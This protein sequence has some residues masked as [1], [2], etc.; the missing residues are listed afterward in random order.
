MAWGTRKLNDGRELPEIGFGTWTAGSGQTVVDQVEQAIETGFNHIDTAQ[1][2]NNEYETG[3]GIKESSEHPWITTK[4]SGKDNKGIRQSLQESLEYLGVKSVDLY[5]IHHP[6]LV[7]GDA[8]ASWAEFEEIKKEGLVKS[9][10][11]SNFQIEDLESIRLAGES[12]PAVN[13]ILLH[14]YVYSQTAPL[15]AY[16]ATHNIVTEAYSSLYPIT[17][18]K[19]GPLDKPLSKIAEKHSASEAGVLFAWARSKGAVIVTTSRQK[20]R[21]EDYLHSGDLELSDK[22]IKQLDEAGGKF[23]AW[24]TKQKALKAVAWGLFAVEGL[25]LV[26]WWISR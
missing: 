13:Q 3:K 8:P 4:W 6:R 16:H 14:P 9:I 1:Y 24:K 19:G 21:L 18:E 26:R 11:V 10:G 7:N 25:A 22:E 15:L 12:T 17:H 2:Y 23:Q 20:S 5:L